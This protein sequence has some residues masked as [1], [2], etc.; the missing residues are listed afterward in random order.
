[1]GSLGAAI[2]LDMATYCSCRS[3]AL[4]TSRVYEAPT[5]PPKIM[6]FLHHHRTTT[7]TASSQAYNSFLC[8][9]CLAFTFK[10]NSST[11][12][13]KASLI[14]NTFQSARQFPISTS[15]RQ[16]A[17]DFQCLFCSSDPVSSLRLPFF[18]SVSLFSLNH[19]SWVVYVLTRCNLQDQELTFF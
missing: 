3:W 18:I 2:E 10:D 13:I 14:D 5:S 4:R 15:R 12:R 9:H 11:T 17:T 6:L 16:Y 1:M 8:L 7:T 19:Q